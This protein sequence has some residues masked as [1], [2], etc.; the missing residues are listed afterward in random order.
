MRCLILIAWF[1][2]LMPAAVVAQTYYDQQ[3]QNREYQNLHQATERA[4]KV[5]SS[6]TSMPAYKSPSSSSPS[7]SYTPSSSYNYGNSN[8]DANAAA[9]NIMREWRK[10]TGKY[11]EEERAEIAERNAGYAEYNNRKAK[12]ATDRR[13]EARRAA[14]HR[15]RDREL[16]DIYARERRTPAQERQW[17]YDSSRVAVINKIYGTGGHVIEGRVYGVLLNKYGNPQKINEDG[18]RMVTDGIKAQE[19]FQVQCKTAS[20]E[21]L[22]SLMNRFIVLPISMV[23]ASSFMAKRFPERRE[24]LMWYEL[25]AIN[26]YYTEEFYGSVNAQHLDEGMND[27]LARRWMKLYDRN[28]TVAMDAMKAN[29]EVRS[30]AL[31]CWTITSER[32]KDR[33]RYYN[34]MMEV[35]AEKPNEWV[36]VIRAEDWDSWKASWPDGF[37][38]TIL[39]RNPGMMLAILARSKALKTQ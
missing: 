38:S 25:M 12:E 29:P 35:P 32:K 31:A 28:P 21:T 24:D 37:L 22:T 27:T 20:Y 11:N 18:R 8:S 14:I 36:K 5:P 39:E 15:E 16:Q 4:Y 13:E 34:L 30:N 26:F 7:S 2:A 23:H 10:N 9:E 19:D 33:I 6:N 1:I 17:K 3:R